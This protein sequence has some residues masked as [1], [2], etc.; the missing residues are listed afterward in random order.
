MKRFST[1][2]SIG[3]AMLIE[4]A[5]HLALATRQA[6]HALGLELF[7]PESPSSTVT[8]VKAPADLDSGVIVREFRERFVSIIANGQGK[9]KGRI[10]QIAHLGYFD[11][12]DLFAVIAELELIL[13]EMEFP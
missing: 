2:K 4:N 3:I 7:A 11:V 9:M 10:F 13:E 1:S 6:C 5:E 8:A 12:A